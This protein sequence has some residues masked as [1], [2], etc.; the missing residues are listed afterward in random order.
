[1]DASLKRHF[2]RALA[3]ETAGTALLVLVGLSF[4]ILMFG[5]GSP[6]PRWLSDA[7]LRRLITGFLFGCTGAAIAVSVLGKWSGA[8]LNPVVTL[9]FW[10]TGTFEP[11]YAA[12]YVLV[13][14][15]GAALGS[16]PLLTWGAIGRSV[17]FG[18][19]TPGAVYGA[20][21]ALLGEVTTTFALIVGLFLFLRHR[22]LRAYAPTYFPVLYA[23]LVLVEAPVSGTSTNPARSFGP[24]LISGVWRGY[25]VYLLGPLLG[26]LLGLAVL[27]ATWLRYAE[28]EVAKLYHFAHNPHGLFHRRPRRSSSWQS[29]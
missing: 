9:A 20:G 5:Q 2:G 21:W 7:A 27:R 16:L 6:V 29:S 3:A 26:M 19:T 18:A 24:A 12:L 8:H 4:V 10:L 25:W 13:Q 15:T 17:Q 11:L 14:L 28:I 23:V 1:L 22:R